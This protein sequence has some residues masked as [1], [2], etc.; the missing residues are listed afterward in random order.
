[1]H[2]V[3]EAARTPRA[4]RLVVIMVVVVVLLVWLGQ[5]TGW[6]PA[7]QPRIV[8]LYCY[9]TL[10]EV[11]QE[12]LLP[13]FRA[14]WLREQG[15][16]V[17]FVTTLAGSGEITDKILS[18]YPAEVA[19]VS[20]EL[21]AYRLPVPWESWRELP[22]EGVLARTPLVIV[23]REGNPKAIV[24]FEDLARGGIDVIHGDPMRSGLA[25]PN[26]FTAWS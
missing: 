20:S 1:M 21:D 16:E 22:Y 19:I 15:E 24:R 6:S 11:M 10:D 4:V 8:A 13:S 7:K 5:R 18:R 17:E 26:R 23:V 9:S 2:C 12:A 14:F 25:E 3:E